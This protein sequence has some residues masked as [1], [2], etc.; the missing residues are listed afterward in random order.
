MPVVAS[1][2]NHIAIKLL[3]RSSFSRFVGILE[4]SQLHRLK[5]EFKEEQGLQG[6]NKADYGDYCRAI[7]FRTN[8]ISGDFSNLRDLVRK[9]EDV[10][11]G[12]TKPA[13]VNFDSAVEQV[14]QSIFGLYPGIFHVLPPDGKGAGPATEIFHGHEIGI[15]C[16]DALYE[17]A[18]NLGVAENSDVYYAYLAFVAES[19]KK[20]AREKA[21]ASDSA[22]E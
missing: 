18:E 3:P 20:Q 15:T 22:I 5:Q 4:A 7:G 6:I 2:V 10:T 19:I 21:A 11:V 16:C 8:I 12:L 13:I 14:A 9:P 17:G 1:V